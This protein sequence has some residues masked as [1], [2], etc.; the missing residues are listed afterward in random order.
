MMLYPTGDKMG[1]FGGRSTDELG[2]AGWVVSTNFQGWP[3]EGWRSG[4]GGPSVLKSDV[5]TSTRP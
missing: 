5:M 2:N 1:G 3:I 4:G